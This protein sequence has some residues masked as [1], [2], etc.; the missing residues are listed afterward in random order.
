M[1]LLKSPKDR[2][3]GGY[4]V[5][6]FLS[7]QPQLGTMDDLMQLTSVCHKNGISCCLDFVMNHTS[8]DHEWAKAARNGDKEAQKDTISL[9]IGTFRRSLKKQFLRYFRQLPRAILLT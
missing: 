7:V 9:T 4:A 1:P 6:D 5:S 2:S 3:D 8:E